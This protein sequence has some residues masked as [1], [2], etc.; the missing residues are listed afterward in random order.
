MEDFVGRDFG[1]GVLWKE[2]TGLTSTSS[3]K[4][5]S[6]KYNYDLSENGSGW[7]VLREGDLKGPKSE[8][9]AKHEEHDTLREAECQSM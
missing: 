2:S 9:N 6:S 7:V 8:D 4:E 5:N 1:L 3:R